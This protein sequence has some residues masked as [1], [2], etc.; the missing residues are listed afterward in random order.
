ML[1][2]DPVSLEAPSTYRVYCSAPRSIGTKFSFS[3]T[4]AAFIASVLL[5]VPVTLEVLE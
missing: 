1:A 4:P 3:L 2:L 5:V